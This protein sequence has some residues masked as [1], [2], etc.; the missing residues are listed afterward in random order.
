[1]AGTSELRGIALMPRLIESGVMRELAEDERSIY[2]L[3]RSNMLLVGSGSRVDALITAVTGLPAH[4]LPVWSGIEPGRESGA[5]E[6]LIVRDV[7]L[8]SNPEQTRLYD[9]IGGW[10]G[11]VR[12]IATAPAPVFPLVARRLFREELYYRLNM[13]CLEPRRSSDALSTVP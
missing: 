8:L 9:A 1:M 3:S 6:T 7:H 13:L 4:S 2:R 11:Q 10:M 12:V 5:P